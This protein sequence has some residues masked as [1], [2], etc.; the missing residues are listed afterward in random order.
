MEGISPFYFSCTQPN[1]DANLYTNIATHAN[2]HTYLSP[3]G[4]CQPDTLS[5]LNATARG[6]AAGLFKQL[7]SADC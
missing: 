6:S 1:S 3:Y 5:N 2:S 4:N 7:L